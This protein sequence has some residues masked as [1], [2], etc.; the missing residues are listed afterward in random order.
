MRRF[1]LAALLAPLSWLTPTG[2]PRPR[3]AENASFWLQLTPRRLEPSGFS[4]FSPAG[5][6]PWRPLLLWSACVSHA[7]LN[8]TGDVGVVKIKPPLPSNDSSFPVSYFSSIC[9]TDLL[10][11]AVAVATAF[12]AF[13]LFNRTITEWASPDWSLYSIVR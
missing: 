2:T 12:R 4:I 8:S 5:I 11:C 1:W 13:L 10:V 3:R 6:S 9:S 7:L